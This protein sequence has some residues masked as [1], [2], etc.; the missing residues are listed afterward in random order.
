MHNREGKASLIRDPKKKEARRIRDQ[1]H[2]INILFPTKK[3]ARAGSHRGV[4]PAHHRM[5]L[6]IRLNQRTGGLVVGGDTS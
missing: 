2:N 5:G 1:Q 6:P 4:I 3:W